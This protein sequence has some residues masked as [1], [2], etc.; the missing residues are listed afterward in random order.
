MRRAIERL[1]FLLLSFAAASLVAFTLLAR[2][3]DRAHRGAE[4]Q[5]LLVNLRPRDVRELTL[6]AVRRVAQSGPG[7]AAASAELVRLGGAAL[8]H[9]LPF[10]ESLEPAARG[11]VALALAPIA[12]RMG[13]ASETELDTPERAVVFFTRFWQD[14]SADFRAQAVRRKVQRLAERSLPLRRKEVVELDTFALGEL[15]EALGR[16]RT[17]DDV[18]RVERLAPVLA[19]VTG[20][21]LVLP[22]SP[23]VAAAAEL[24]TR[25]HDWELDHGPDFATLD[26]PG[27]LAAFVMQTRYF[28]FLAS[29]RRA[30]LGDAPATAA[31][32]AEV[33]TLGRETIPRVLGALVLAMGLALALARA[34]AAGPSRHAAV[35]LG[36]TTVGSFSLSGLAVR[37]GAL[38]SVAVVL[39][40]SVGLGALLVLELD[41][42]PPGQSRLKRVVGR[43]GML[44]PLALAA[45]LA[46]EATNQ[47]GLGALIR[48]ARDA[49]D[50]DTLM[51]I[52]LLL[53]ATS[54][55]GILVQDTRAASSE[56]PPLS[57]TELV[58]G[59][60]GRGAV[61]TVGGIVG[62]YASLGALHSFMPSWADDLARAAG[63]TL[64]VALGATALAAAVTIMLGVLAG[65]ISRTADT[66]LSRTSE[67]YL[68]LPQPLIAGSALVLGGAFGPALLGALRGIEVAVALRARLADQRAFEDFEPPSLG[69]SPLSPYLKRVLP[70]AVAPIATLL[71]LTGAWVATF[72]GAFAAL[73]APLAP[74]LG[75]LSGF[76]GV[77]GL[78]A[79]VLLAALV[80]A[81]CW[82]VRDIAPRAEHLET[83]GA[84]VVLPLKR[85]IDS[86]RPG[87]PGRGATPPAEP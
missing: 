9:V 20:M 64:V 4:P 56:H 48:R 72:E 42:L 30:V 38:G 34:L 66:L 68:A 2:L 19:H 36:A 11:R 60:R 44:L 87:E 69:R 62:L 14:R 47:R 45:E 6:A 46:A 52:A 26:G 7:A 57:T 53:S 13:V 33:G 84:P 70:T 41:G 32:I 25:W 10:L 39:M 43:A 27:R 12:Q 79:L 50:V 21:A 16:V 29:A 24:V 15:L 3:S 28:R 17:P 82:L 86:V 85:R 51:W 54:C 55:L 73:G 37:A 40:V 35:V 23:S 75:V 22:A 8:P 65:G 83:P 5:P 67:L 63:H 31:R 58:P 71:A 49:A 81:L 61:L 74:S 76:G 80:S 77:L 59:R 78:A 18:R 1:T